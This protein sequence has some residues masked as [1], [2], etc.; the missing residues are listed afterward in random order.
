[1]Q[2]FLSLG[3]VLA[4][5][6]LWLTS[7]GAQERKGIITG[8]II[9]SAKA[10]LQGASIELQPTGRKTAS[11]NTGQF[12]FTDVAAGTYTVSI[13]FVGMSSYS[14]EITVTGGQTTRVEAQMDVAS[15]ADSV[16]VT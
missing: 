6:A 16:T 9:D 8:S 4:F 14:K 3:C 12:S 15:V 2:R 7:A 1:M 10:V 13:S 5:C 11:D